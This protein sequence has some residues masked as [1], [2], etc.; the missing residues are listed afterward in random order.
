MLEVD[1]KYINID[2]QG[3]LSNFSDWC[4]EVVVFLAEQEN[5]RLTDAHWEV[6]YFVQEFYKKFHISPAVRILVK[7]IEKQYGPEKSSS[8][9]LFTL[10]PKGPAKQATKLAGLP[11]PTKCL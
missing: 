7:A 9:Y 4:E 10:F 8:R 6:I 2:A 11:K 5:I 3:Y 1:G